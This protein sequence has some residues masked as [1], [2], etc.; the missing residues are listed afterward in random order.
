MGIPLGKR[1]FGFPIPIGKFQNSQWEKIREKYRVLL[2][3]HKKKP[4]NVRKNSG[5]FFVTFFYSQKIPSNML[6]KYSL[7]TLE[8]ISPCLIDI[9][10]KN[11]LFSV[12]KSPWFPIGKN[13]PNPHFSPFPMGRT[14]DGELPPLL[15]Y[16]SDSY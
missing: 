10:M 13:I 14:F 4:I 15:T 9:F 7:L 16:K 5:N 11:S 1:N 2:A 8:S 6:W 12:A 3:N